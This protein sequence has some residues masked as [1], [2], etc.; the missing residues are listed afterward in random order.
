MNVTWVGLAFI[1][2]LP[3]LTVR[4]CAFITVVG[5]IAF[6]KA[7]IKAGDIPIPIFLGFVTLGSI[8]FLLRMRSRLTPAFT[9]GVLALWATAMATLEFRGSQTLAARALS[10]YWITSLLILAGLLRAIRSG[11]LDEGLQKIL[12]RSVAFALTIVFFFGVGQYMMGIEWLQ[13]PGLTIAF[14]DSY[15][16]KPLLFEGGV[17]VPSTYQNGNLLGIVAACLMWYFVLVRRTR[18]SLV[19]VAMAII[20][21]VISGSRSAILALIATAFFYFVVKSRPLAVVGACFL[22]GAGSLL[23]GQVAPSLGARYAIGSIFQSGAGGRDLQ[24]AYWWKHLNLN[25]LLFGDP[26]W[27]VQGAGAGV[28]EH[29]LVEGLPGII[30]QVGLIGV[31]LLIVVICIAVSGAFKRG[32]GYVLLP[33]LFASVIDSSY[34]SFPVLWTS[35]LLASLALTTEDQRESAR[36]AATYATGR[37]SSVRH[38]VSEPQGIALQQVTR[39]PSPLRQSDGLVQR[40]RS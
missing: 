30:Q 9:V 2:V 4:R 27:R 34:E 21:V 28:S 5:L 31:A 6:P 3:L 17:K 1:L 8:V 16:A 29:A 23:L 39:K 25:Q 19:F 18:V 15:A 26:Q 22:A 36:G 12:H 13:V 7:G 14:G 33:V 10:A 20:L 24:W 40:G 11:D 37:Q 35:F 38:A 32:Y